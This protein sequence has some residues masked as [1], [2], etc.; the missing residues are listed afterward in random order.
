LA[1]DNKA[2]KS[3]PVPVVQLASRWSKFIRFEIRTG[4]GAEPL[5]W[6]LL[7]LG[8]EADQPA[9]LDGTTNPEVQWGLS[10]EAAA[11]VSPGVYRIVA[12]LEV[13]A[14]DAANWRGRVESAPVV[15]TIEAR[16]ASFQ[17]PGAAES[18]MA[19]A[20]YWAHTRNWDKSLA[21]AES[22]L[23]ND[24]K[25]IEGHALLGDALA[26][27]PGAKGAL[28]AYGTAINLYKQKYQ[29]PKYEDPDYLYARVAQIMRENPPKGLIPQNPTDPM[30]AKAR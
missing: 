9:A 16:P 13:A 25:S 3:Q 12:V 15:L 26:A 18:D 17:G 1:A 8:G 20:R 24:P 23:R 27:R 30:P 28:T 29:G 10:P 4:R 7:S 22:A 14:G 21:A 2:S 11:R 5:A 6:P 19:E